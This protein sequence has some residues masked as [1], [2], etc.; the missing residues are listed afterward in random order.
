MFSYRSE[1]FWVESRYRNLCKLT[2]F[3]GN[4]RI[5]TLQT[6]RKAKM[7]SLSLFFSP[8]PS[9]YLLELGNIPEC[10][11]YLPD[12]RLVLSL[13][14]SS[15]TFGFLSEFCIVLRLNFTLYSTEELPSAAQCRIWESGVK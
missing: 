3:G 10:R 5:F 8:F 14:I 12:V 7:L 11:L 2:G 13:C 6:L 15:Q 1:Y 9:S 4:V